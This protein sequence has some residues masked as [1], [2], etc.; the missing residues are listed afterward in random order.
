MERESEKLDNIIH[1]LRRSEPVLISKDEIEEVII[2]R[3]SKRGNLEIFLSGTVDLLFRWIYIRWVRRSMVA[4]SILLVVLF[5]WQ[6]SV[7][8]K[9]I[10]YLSSQTIS[11]EQEKILD[12]PGIIEKKLMMYKLSGKKIPVQYVTISKK[13]MDLLLESINDLEG[14]Y[15]DLIYLI[16]DD[17]ELKKYIEDKIIELKKTKVKL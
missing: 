1:L 4:V 7:L 9:Q 6:Q 3:I 5:I 2:E 13:Q 17:P 8:M 15:N 10:N 11:H 14:K 12:E 16:Q